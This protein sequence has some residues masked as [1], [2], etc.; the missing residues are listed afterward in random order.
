MKAM[1][2][3]QHGGLD[4]FQ[5]RDRPEP[6]LREQEIL[7]R[8]Q[9]T[10]VNPVDYKIRRGSMITRKFPLILGYDVSG[11]VVALGKAVSQFKLGD[12]VYASP[13][14]FGDGANAQYVAVDSRTAALKPQSLDH[15]ASAVL[16][17]VCLTAWES[18][19]ARVRIPHGQTVLIHA[20]AGGV[21]HIAVQLA[22][23][24]GCRVITTAGRDESIGFC[25][26]T[27][28]ADEVIDY[29]ATDFSARMME[30]TRG[31]GAPVILDFVG[32]EVFEKSMEC[33]AVN[34][35]LVTIVPTT[36]AAITDKL[37][38]KNVSLHYEFM[39]APTLYGIEPERQGEILRIIANLVDAG[40]L[41]PHI[42]HRIPLSELAKGH[43][44]QEQGHVIGKVAVL[45]AEDEEMVVGGSEQQLSH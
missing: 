22:K 7:I 33:I 4:V 26:E 8:V 40:H 23:L 29:R 24:H 41:Q 3:N 11:T 18:L 45:V 31:K 36:T 10:S 20:G 38:L 15:V 42:S 14:L 39:G 32:G 17:L 5:F 9:A 12:E 28:K 19:H 37:F 44:L 21:G 1:V 25:R 16:P 43:E 13:N 27:L 34:G 2:I 6:T 30:I 35:Q